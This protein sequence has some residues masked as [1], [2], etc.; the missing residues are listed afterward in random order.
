MWEALT[1]DA[2]FH[3]KPLASSAVASFSNYECRLNNLCG[4]YGGSREALSA[5]APLTKDQTIPHL[6]AH[7][8][9]PVYIEFARGCF[10]CPASSPFLQSSYCWCSNC[11]KSI[12]IDAPTFNCI[13]CLSFAVARMTGQVSQAI[14]YLLFA[15]GQ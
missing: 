3:S 8:S 1:L 4:S 12:E 2:H 13:D 9:D 5:T 15:D 14:L 10:H 7:E 11:A 6:T